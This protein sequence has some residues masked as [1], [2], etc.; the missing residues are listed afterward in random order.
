MI[1]KA[2]RICKKAHKGQKRWN[3]DPYFTHPFRVAASLD[4]LDEDVVVAAYLHDVLED[5]EWTEADLLSEIPY[6][7]IEIVKIVTK[8]KNESYRD[9]IMRIGMSGNTDAMLVKM[10]DISDNLSDLK[11]GSL[12]DKYEL[13]YV[14][15]EGFYIQRKM[16][17]EGSD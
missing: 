11:P 16:E 6:P 4:Y 1:S 9:F 17:N 7:A 5:T 13:A 2:K 14:L 10:S 12:R 3:G 15:L 8:G